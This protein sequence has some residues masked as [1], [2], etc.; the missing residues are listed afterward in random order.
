[1]NKFKKGD[2]IIC[3]NTDNHEELVKDKIYEVEKPDGD[4]VYLKGC[5][6]GYFNFLFRKECEYCEK[7]KGICKENKTELGIELH[8]G[9][10]HLVAY[11]TDKHNWGISVQCKINY[12]PMCGR[13]LLEKEK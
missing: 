10:G 1:M 7:G 5:K 11:G 8:S 4:F 9:S 2:K 12:C 3:I 6:Y 13:K